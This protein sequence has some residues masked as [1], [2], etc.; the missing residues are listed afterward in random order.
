MWKRAWQT[1]H[2]ALLSNVNNFSEHQ[3][4]TR[5]LCWPWWIQTWTRPFCYLIWTWAKLWTLS[6][7]QKWP[8]AL[9]HPSDSCF[10]TN[11]NLSFPFF[12]RRP[13]KIPYHRLAWQYPTPT[14]ACFSPQV[15]WH[16]PK[17]CKVFLTPSDW[18]AIC[19]PATSN[20]PN[21]WVPADF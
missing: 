14:Q 19:S 17:S 3:L 13:F 12:L 11:Y 7:S 20:K 10:F 21:R 1:G 15:T 5:S 2:G 6:K 8:P 16:Q 4:H 18:C 9:T